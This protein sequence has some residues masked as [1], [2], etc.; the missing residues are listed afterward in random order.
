MTL[1]EELYHYQ[2]RVPKA[3]EH[4][5]KI[6]PI[7]M[8]SYLLRFGVEDEPINPGGATW[9]GDSKLHFRSG[10]TKGLFG[11]YIK[12]ADSLTKVE[13]NAS[14]ITYT[15]GSKKK[16]A[17]I[18][19]YGG[20]VPSHGKM[21]KWMFWQYKLTKNPFWRIMALSVKKKKG[22][23]IKQRPTFG[24][25]MKLFGQ[26]ELPKFTQRLMDIIFGETKL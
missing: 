4:A 8:Q 14:G 20:F 2:K 22:I 23:N 7:L 19:E 9:S 15:F 24:P 16:Y 10:N 5:K 17:E 13:I 21:E 1:W 6:L 18:H 12:G 26:V 11:S 3:L 25:A